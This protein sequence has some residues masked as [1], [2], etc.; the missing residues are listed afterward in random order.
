LNGYKTNPTP[1]PL[2]NSCVGS[3]PKILLY[4]GGRQIKRFGD[5]RRNGNDKMQKI[6][7]VLGGK[8]IAY[9]LGLLFIYKHVVGHYNH[10]NKQF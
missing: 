3:K 7:L 4:L 1:Y 8:V 10:L 2:R 9:H 5:W 6:W